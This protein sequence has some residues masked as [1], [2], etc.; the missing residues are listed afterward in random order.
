MD[1]QEI[2]LRIR[3]RILNQIAYLNQVKEK[4]TFPE[5]CRTFLQF[6]DCLLEMKLNPSNIYPIIKRLIKLLQ[7]DYNMITGLN[8]LLPFDIVLEVHRENDNH[9]HSSASVS[10]KQI[11]S[12][13][14]DEMNQEFQKAMKDNNDFVLAVHEHFSNEQIDFNGFIQ[15]LQAY[16]LKKMSV[17]ESMIAEH[18]LVRDVT[19]LVKNENIIEMLNQLRFPE[20]LAVIAFQIKCM[21]KL[22]ADIYDDSIKK[23]EEKFFQEIRKSTELEPEIKKEYFKV[24]SETA[25]KM[26]NDEPVNRDEVRAVVAEIFKDR[27]E[28]LIHLRNVV[29]L[30]SLTL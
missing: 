13:T 17:D 10:C 8:S 26:W 25:V 4:F 27:A 23:S 22:Q 1:R 14:L 19:E 29:K 16:R 21:P 20:Y 11:T 24:M 7:T 5:K 3:S 6:S 12:A 9:S 2:D 15:I 30:E 28:F 18:A